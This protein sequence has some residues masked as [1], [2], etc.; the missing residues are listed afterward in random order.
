MTTTQELQELIDTRFGGVISDGSH[1]A[2]AAACSMEIISVY[3]GIEWTDDPATVRSFDYRNLNDGCWS[4]D[5]VRT[6]HLLPLMAAMDGSLDW[7]ADRQQAFIEEIIRE[8][9]RRIIPGL[10]DLPEDVRAACR[11]VKTLAECRNAGLLA[12]SA[13]PAMMDWPA[14]EWAASDVVW[15][16]ARAAERQPAGAARGVASASRNAAAALLIAPE[17]AAE[18]PPEAADGDAVLK[19]ACDIWIKAASYAAG[20]GSR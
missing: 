1:R 10:P 20:D 14:A 7:P 9:V 11:E 4:T 19:I 12:A 18:T 15:A 5:A 13:L 3:R 6:V 8:T 16:A 2:G 17:I